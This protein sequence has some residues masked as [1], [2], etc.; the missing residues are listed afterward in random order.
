VH[1]LGRTVRVLITTSVGVVEPAQVTL[2]HTNLPF[3]RVRLTAQSPP[4]DTIV[5]HIRTDLDTGSDAIPVTVLRPGL[6]LIA[7]PKRIAG[8]GLEVA[9]LAVMADVARPRGAATVTLTADRGKVEPVRAALD[10]SGTATSSIR[11]SGL[12]RATVTAQSQ[13]FQP[14]TEVVDF[15]FPKAFLIAA[16]IGGLLG[17]FVREG[18]AEWQDKQHVGLWGFITGVVLAALVGMVVVVAWALGINL[19]DIKPVAGSG[20]ALIGVVAALGAIGGLSLI[21]KKLGNPP[22]AR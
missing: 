3:T 21:A 16:V 8:Y 1:R 4:P 5:L 9:T 20:E 19:L 6:R 10:S 13:S 15:V 11:S 17:G 7:T 14:A 12:G 18:Y 2:D 22:P